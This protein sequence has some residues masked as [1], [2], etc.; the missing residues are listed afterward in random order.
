[1]VKSLSKH[2]KPGLIAYKASEYWKHEPK[3]CKD[4][5]YKTR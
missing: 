4:L 2:Y 1:M 5:L 3:K